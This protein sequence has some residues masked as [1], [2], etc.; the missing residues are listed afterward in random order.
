MARQIILL[1]V[2]SAIIAI[3]PAGAQP[4]STGPEK[5]ESAPLASCDEFLP[6]RSR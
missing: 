2:S 5:K 1:A 6:A 4:R 3:S